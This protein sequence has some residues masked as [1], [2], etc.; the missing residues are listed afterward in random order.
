MLNYYIDFDEKSEL[1]P[2][3]PILISKTFP[4]YLYGFGHSFA[5]CRY[6]TEREHHNGYLLVYTIAG[7]G[8]I[9]FRGT[10]QVLGPGDI[11]LIDC[12]EYHYYST[13][14]SGNWEKY[15]I[16]FDGIGSKGYFDL[17]NGNS[18][19]IINL[20]DPS[21]FIR[22]MLEIPGYLTSQIL[23]SDLKISFLISGI[24]TE[25]T[26]N[27]KKS[28]N[29]ASPQITGTITN[30]VEY[31][32]KNLHKDIRISDIASEV[33]LSPFYFSR[34]FKEYIGSSPHEYLI[35]HRIDTSKKLLKQ[36]GVCV[37]EIAE[38]TG[39]SDVNNFIR[40]F[41]KLTGTTPLHYRR[42]WI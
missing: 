29:A 27:G 15:W 21:Q 22:F 10:S 37:E 26:L 34:I 7:T 5:G 16:H 4:F 2:Y 40:V 39:F 18:L 33:H 17:V 13:G 28:I 9:K 12:M 24:L 14:P 30:A 6:F 41:K 42:Y 19:N 38:K 25:L 31:I 11:F 1:I 35:R 3:T 32:N 36:T 23:Q 20:K 8:L